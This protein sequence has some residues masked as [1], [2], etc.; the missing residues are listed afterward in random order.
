MQKIELTNT[1]PAVFAGRENNNSEVW[2]QN[3]T[4]E[5]DKSY[6]ISAESGTGKSSLCS[7]LYGFRNDYSGKICFDDTNVASLDMLRWSEIRTKHLAYLPQELRLFG[8]L[9]ALENVELKNKL[10]GYKSRDAILRLFDELGIADKANSPV[11]HLSIGQQQRVA[12][13]RTLC[14]PCDFILLDEPVSHL[15]SNNNAIVARIVSDEA[16][17]QGAGII[18]TSVGN[19]VLLTINKEL[20]L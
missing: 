13:I 10:T 1:L 7:Y 19:N 15:D 16:T 4:F 2:L 20:K 14:Q 17:R 6:L 8:E 11:A 9:T 12:I 3:V 18:A 5:R